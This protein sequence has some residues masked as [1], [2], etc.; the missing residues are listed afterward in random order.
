MLL[1][2]VKGVLSAWELVVDLACDVALEASHRFFLGAAL[3]HLSGDVAAGA[4]VADHAGDDD[5]PECRVGL[6]VA[7]AVE[8]VPLSFAGAGID[9]GDTAEVR[10]RGFA[11]ESFGVVAGGDQQC[12]GDVGADPAD[13]DELGGGVGGEG[14][15]DLVDLG[16]LGFECD[17]PVS[18]GA[19]RE[20]GEGV[21]VASW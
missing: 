11:A 19:Q 1:G 7:A 10:E 3:V 18:Q 12:G 13:G 8:A 9:R 5:V 15:E 16:D 2:V 21:D 20:S 6:P 14:G 17:R 4:F